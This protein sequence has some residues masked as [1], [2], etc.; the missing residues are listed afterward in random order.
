M[1]W[2]R[3]IPAKGRTDIVI[4]LDYLAYGNDGDFVD[5]GKLTV[6]WTFY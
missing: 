4:K 2:F 6:N 5:L 3:N 1:V